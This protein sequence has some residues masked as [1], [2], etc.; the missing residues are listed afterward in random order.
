MVMHLAFSSLFSLNAASAVRGIAVVDSRAC[1][2]MRS[3]PW[4]CAFR[5]KLLLQTRIH[6]FNSPSP[7]PALFYR[8]LKTT[9]QLMKALIADSQFSS[10]TLREQLSAHGV[11]VVISYPANQS[12]G[13]AKLLRVDKYF[14]THGP[15]VEKQI[16]TQDLNGIDQLLQNLFRLWLAPSQIL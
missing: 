12:K 1:M 10:R 6:P 13:E 15:V 7:R 14:R 8:A 9:G 3:R 16:Y 4:L 11:G 2:V 5:V